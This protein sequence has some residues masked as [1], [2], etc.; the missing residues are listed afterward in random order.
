MLAGLTTALV[1][2]SLTI[3]AMFTKTDIRV[4][5]ALVFVLYLAMLP[6]CIIGA[7]L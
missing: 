1:T 3:Y 7:I 5:M 2:I 6:M 4:F